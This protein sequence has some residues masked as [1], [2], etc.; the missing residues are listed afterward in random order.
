MGAQY[1]VI[2]FDIT[3]DGSQ[4]VVGMDINR[5]T[6]T[7]NLVS[8]PRI[9][10]KRLSDRGTRRMETCVSTDEP[11]REIIRLLVVQE[12]NTEE[13]IGYMRMTVKMRSLNIAKRIQNLTHAHLG[14]MEGSNERIYEEDG[15][16]T[17]DLGN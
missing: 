6:V 5:Y 14:C 4:I 3:N 2:H 15:W 13:L 8:P 7:Y 10:L 12:I 16:M 1:V 11:I 17:L 9:I